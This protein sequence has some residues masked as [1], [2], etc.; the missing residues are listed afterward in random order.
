MNHSHVNDHLSP[1][2]QVA[3]ATLKALRPLVTEFNY[4]R[5]AGLEIVVPPEIEAEYVKEHGAEGQN[6]LDLLLGRKQTI[7][8]VNIKVFMRLEDTSAPSDC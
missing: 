5:S 2:L 4:A 6:F 1:E 3:L 8:S 7:A